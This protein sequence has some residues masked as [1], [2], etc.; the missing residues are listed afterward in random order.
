MPEEGHRSS[1]VS[2]SPADLRDADA[3]RRGVEGADVVVHLAYAIHGVRPNEDTLFAVNV[4][5]A[6]QVADAAVDTGARR[7]VYA[8]SA[9]VYGFHP[10]NPVPLTE[11]TPIRASS[12]HFYGRHKAQ[13]ELLIDQA[14]RGASIDTYVFRPGV[15]VG[16]QVAAGTLN[17]IPRPLLQSGLAA[18]KGALKVGLG[19]PVPVPPITLQAL[20]HNDVAAALELAVL[21]R[22]DAGVYNLAGDGV[23][24][25][26]EVPGLL[27]LPPAPIPRELNLWAARWLAVAAPALPLLGWAEAAT[28]PLILDTSKA[29]D[30]LGWRPRYSTRAA[31]RATA[32]AAW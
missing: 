15:I 10:D 20:H 22:G 18:L 9:A 30:E 29:R 31:L 23:V 8:S 13:A 32:P 19:P 26:D 12:R 1:K 7:L 24:A 3:V 28:A 27:G 17:G 5:G 6:R 21:G 2:F 25:G 11:H 16:P 14:T 4:E